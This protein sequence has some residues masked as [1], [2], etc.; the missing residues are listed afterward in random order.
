MAETFAHCQPMT[1]DLSQWNVSQVTNL[2]AAFEGALN[3][4]GSDLSAWDV[5][6]VT[7]LQS[8][9]A[10]SP[11]FNARQLND[12]DVFRV[13]DMTNT[14]QGATGFNRDLS[15]WNVMAVTSFQSMFAPVK[16]SYRYFG[17]VCRCSNQFNL[18]DASDPASH[19]NADHD[20]L[21]SGISAACHGKCA[22]DIQQISPTAG[23]NGS[24][25]LPHGKVQRVGGTSASRARKQETHALEQ[26]GGRDT[27]SDCS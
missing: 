4:R 3:F 17:W 13:T 9:F 6:R 5:S 1:I 18:S 15:S 27:S 20:Q 10:R 14:F 12:W 11:L 23:A 24:Q 21:G 16:L 7:N 26:V 22:M 25:S 19:P 2:R 8:T